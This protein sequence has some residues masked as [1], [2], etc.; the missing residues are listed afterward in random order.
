[1]T[2]GPGQMLRLISHGSDMGEGQGTFLSSVINLSA[3]S[4]GCSI[5]ALPRVFAVC[6]MTWS[7]LF[8]VIFSVCPGGWRPTSCHE[9]MRI[10]R[11]YF[12]C[13]Q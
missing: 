7:L 6:G 10:S 5:L 3:A 2:T 1:M 9:F 4:M 8:L 13:K 11:S 12:L